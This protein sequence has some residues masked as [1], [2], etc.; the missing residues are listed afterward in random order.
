MAGYYIPRGGAIY[1]VNKGPSAGSEWKQ[2]YSGL[3]VKVKRQ[4]GIKKKCVFYLMHPR[5]TAASF[6]VAVSHETEL[7]SR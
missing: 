1:M 3:S 5:F 4:T 6:A 2:T 7:K